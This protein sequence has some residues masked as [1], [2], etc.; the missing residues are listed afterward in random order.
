M[1]MILRTVPSV[2]PNDADTQGLLKHGGL[3]V[4]LRAERLRC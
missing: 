2:M 3:A 4:R 1:V